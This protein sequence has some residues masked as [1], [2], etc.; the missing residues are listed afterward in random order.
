MSSEDQNVHNIERSCLSLISWCP[1]RATRTKLHKMYSDTKN[2]LINDPVD[3]LGNEAAIVS[4]SIFVVGAF[5]DYL[6][7]ALE[8]TEE[9]YGVII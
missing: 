4:A 2:K 8:F 7:E 5:V 9:S 1:D 6:N 3:P